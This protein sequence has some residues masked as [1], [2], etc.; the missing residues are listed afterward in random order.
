MAHLGMLCFGL[1]VG[2]LLCLGLVYI[3]DWTS[4]VKAAT[5]ILGA[6]S[7]AAIF[8][9]LDVLNIES[10]K[11]AIFA[12]P[13]GLFIALLWSFTQ[14]AAANIG[15]GDGK[16]QFFGWGHLVGVVGITTMLVTF[17]VLQDAQINNITNQW[18]LGI[19][20]AISFSFI[21]FMLYNAF[22][23]IKRR[24]DGPPAGLVTPGPRT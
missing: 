11:D 2:T 18:I 5:Y 7:S 10:N 4:F 24:P 9:F 20:V 12:Y 23:A 8:K 1:F 14:Y 19:I 13:I 17:T 21:A 6:I 15:S 3:T 16:L 22:T